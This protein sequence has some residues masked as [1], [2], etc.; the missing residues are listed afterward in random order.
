MNPTFEHAFFGIILGLVVTVEIFG[1][2]L[3]IAE[4]ADKKYNRKIR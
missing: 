1:S 4:W 3:R 2:F